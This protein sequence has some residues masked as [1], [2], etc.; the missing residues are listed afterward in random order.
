MRSFRLILVAVRELRQRRN[1][2]IERAASIAAG[3]GARL[4]LFHDLAAPVYVDTFLGGGESLEEFTRATRATA[5]RRLERLAEPLRARGLKVTTATVWDY[6]PYEAL[7]R[8]AVAIR[9]DLIVTIK[10]GHH[11]L[12]SLLGYTDWELLRAS[13][14]PVLLIKNSRYRPRAAVLAAIDPLHAA[15]K[16]AG[17]EQQILGNAAALA[18]ALD[19]P[20]HAVH[21]LTPWQRSTTDRVALVS[22]QARAA[23]VR[24]SRTHLLEGNPDTLLPATARRLRAGAVVMG[25]MSRRGLQRLFV[26]NSAERLLDDLHCDVLVV[27]P[28]RFVMRVP[29]T[30]RGIYFLSTMPLA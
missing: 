15:A 24:P 5:L 30:R 9:A 21:V 12:P 19:S 2:A 6:P 28:P 10:R 1:L 17:L 13:P 22:S 29:R 26:G 7:V 18:Q 3:C 25:A 14:M 11:R 16:S 20:L 4:E 27:K 23:G 8:R